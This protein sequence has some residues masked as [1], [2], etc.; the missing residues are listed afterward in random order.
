MRCCKGGR[1]GRVHVALGHLYLREKILIAHRELP[2]GA[3]CVWERVAAGVLVR[4]YSQGLCA[5]VVAL[6]LKGVAGKLARCKLNLCRDPVV[7]PLCI[8][9]LVPF[10]QIEVH[11]IVYKA[12][13]VPAQGR[14][15]AYALRE[16][17][18]IFFAAFPDAVFCY[19]RRVLDIAFV[20]LAS[21][22][23][24][25][26]IP[27]AAG[28]VPVSA[29]NVKPRYYVGPVYVLPFQFIQPLSAPVLERIGEYLADRVKV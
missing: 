8:A 4:L 28:E 25:L 1:F 20:L 15:F 5:V 16:Y 18:A 3:C 23:A 24:K 9:V 27:V 17:V 22:Q 21:R 14:N 12:K 29:V 7:E 10:V 19:G 6:K 2:G 26:I 13:N 11:R